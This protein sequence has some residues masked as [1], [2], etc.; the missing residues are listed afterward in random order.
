M[1]QKKIGTLLAA[2]A[3][4]LGTSGASAQQPTITKVADLV[5][6]GYL[7]QL[8]DNGKWAV[9]F[10]QSLISEGSYSFPRL[11]DIE[12]KKQIDL[13]TDTQATTIGEMVAY[14]V[15]DDGSLVV[16]QFS[17]LPA[18]WYADKGEWQT[19]PLKSGYTFGYVRRVTP[20][21][22]YALATERNNGGVTETITLWDLTGDTPKDITPT[23]I[24]KPIG[25]SGILEEY[26]QI[27]A[28][29]LSP[30]G[31]KFLGLVAFSYG[32]ETWSFIY[33]LD[34]NSWKGI[35]YDVTETS[36]GYKFTRT[37]SGYLTIE[38]ARFQP[39]SD[40]VYG[41]AY[42]EDD[43][44]AVYVYD[45]STS[46]VELIDGSEGMEFGGV[47]AEG[48]I[49]ASMAVSTG[50]IRNWY[51]KSGQYWYDF[52]I[53]TRQLWG[54]DWQEDITKD[55]YGYTGTFTSVSDNGLTLLATDFSD[56][57]YSTFVI[58]TSQPM[59]ELTKGINL[60][61]NY[62]V[63]PVS[64][65][66]FAVLKEVK[67]T[68]DREIEV[69]GSYNSAQ[70]LDSEGN[71]V[72]TSIAFSQDAGSSKILSIQFRNR[73]LE[74]GKEYT[75]VIPAGTVGVSG[76][77]DRTNNEITVK[78]KGRPDSPVAPTII[79]PA[80]GSEL[81]RINA[82]SNPVAVTFDSDIA[83]VDNG[84]LMYLYLLNGDNE[85]ERICVLNGSITGSVLTIYPVLEQRLAKGSEY[86]I[87]IEANTVSDIS[88]SDPN[89]E[90]VI[91]YTGS[92]VPSAGIT[93]QIF[94]DDFNSGLSYDQWMAYDGD[95]LTPATEVANMGFAVDLPWWIVRDSQY[96]FD[97]NAIAS[98]SMYENPGQ[99]DDWLVTTALYI[100]DETAVLTFKSQ[101]WLSSKSDYLKVYVYASDDIYTAL[102]S[103]IVNNIRYDGDLVYNELQSPGASDDLMEGDWRENTI[104]LDK[105][106]GKFIYIAF[107][108]DN[109]NQS[110]VMVDDVL[111]KRDIKFSLTNLTPTSVLAKDDVEVKGT[112][113]IES[114]TNTYKGYKL[115]L[116]D[117]DNTVIST[118]ADADEE[119]SKGW[120][121]DFTFPDKL[122]LTI[123]REAN[124]TINVTVGE[125]N[126][127]LEGSVQDLVFQTQ[128]KVVL[129]E[130]TG[131]GCPNCPLG[132][133]A[134]DWIEKDFPGL[135]I[136]LGIHTY[137]GD[138]FA[139]AKAYQLQSFLGLSAAPT[140]RINRG[141]IASPI[142]ISDKD[143]YL[144]KGMGVWYDYVYTALN[145]LA[146]AD[147]TINSV[148]FA[149]D[150]YKVNVEV[151]YA[152][153]MDNQN[154]N[155][156]TVVTENGL[157]GV[158]DNNRY[159][160]T[161]TALGEW[162]NGGIYGQASVPY[163]YNHVVRTWEGTTCN[164]TGGYIP[165]SVKGGESYTANIEVSNAS[166]RVLFTENTGVTV[167]MI[168]ANTGL[169]L[170]ADYQPMG[171]VSGIENV[172]TDN[173]NDI[174]VSTYNGT[175]RVN[176]DSEA[177][178]AVYGI[179]GRLIATGSGNGDFTIDNV[180]AGLTVVVVKTA[181]AVKTFKLLVK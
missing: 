142:S 55:D 17:N 34:T 84:G 85:R 167:M 49:F 22:R 8:S 72:A 64:N 79:A 5:R 153:D 112:L 169:V 121:Y 107:V 160:V 42:T 141:P 166:S 73:R 100:P 48:S 77:T 91:H 30:D 75:V 14:D 138:S 40:L 41:E 162:G 110:M 97:E 9:G 43:Q 150:K 171:Y 2:L 27:R 148:E 120:T 82:T 132:I 78:Y 139:T 36:T 25:M 51:V 105:Y 50:P 90:I 12:N 28:L 164:G 52:R 93:D 47:D 89:E 59:S 65:A 179:D 69:L 103:T 175:I 94:F 118:I 133:A 74:V 143:E 111:V 129:E 88:G 102:T 124:Y 117:A 108:N 61:D 7:E 173:G 96:V 53:M 136:P 10:G 151:K 3:M 60:L 58:E 134:V 154:I 18:L 38:G 46:T 62:Y 63:T 98:H 92:Y 45:P 113:T 15:T 159:N 6:G 147:V 54:I 178:A 99:S 145:E 67:V 126:D 140:G 19:L 181:N 70:L 172:S 101:S 115:E 114:E 95:Q 21:G 131:Q 116:L 123:G 137:T 23:N 4:L 119:M 170:N 26:Q 128:R 29:D 174:S 86:E 76:D 155:L 37:G 35:G 156:F 125:D 56:S 24:P 68:F 71:P 127:K 16:G 149:D 66:S 57:P 83:S 165:S 135:L 39:G 31:K 152:L 109:R 104:K 130:F 144:Y 168:D 33:D 158:Q 176:C 163:V 13:Y 180:A 20:D 161:A 1:K 87:V 44:A 80:D 157:N 11:Y 177:S 106:A 81:P 146:P 122:P 32:G